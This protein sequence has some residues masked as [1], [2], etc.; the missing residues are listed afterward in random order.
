MALNFDQIGQGI[1]EGLFARED[2][3]KEILFKAVDNRLKQ[4]DKDYDR[5]SVEFVKE[6]NG[7]IAEATQPDGSIALDAETLAGYRRLIVKYS[8]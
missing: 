3:T 1:V 7:Y 8:S 5:D 4:A 2:P 6:L